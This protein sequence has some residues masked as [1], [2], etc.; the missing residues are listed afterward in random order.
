MEYKNPWNIKIMEYKNQN[1]QATRIKK[2][3]IFG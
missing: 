1:G 2:E 3:E